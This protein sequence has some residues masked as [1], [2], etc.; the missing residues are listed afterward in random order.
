MASRDP[1]GTGPATSPGQ[2]STAASASTA[3][4]V[5]AAEAGS[6]A[7]AGPD[8]DGAG[9]GAGETEGLATKASAV[10]PGAPATSTGEP[11]TTAEAEPRTE[12]ETGTAPETGTTPESESR[13]ATHTA[14]RTR[15]STSA[16]RARPW[17][18]ARGAAHPP[19][20]PTKPVIAAALV[21]GLLLIGAPFLVAGLS[22]PDDGSPSAS[23][24]EPAGSR[25]GPDGS[26]PGVVPGQQDAP[27]SGRV[28][29]SGA[30]PKAGAP[31]ASGGGPV[32][33]LHEGGTAL[34][35]GGTQPVG[36]KPGPG[37]PKGVDTTP[38]TGTKPSG[39]SGGNGNGAAPGGGASGGTG[40]GTQPVRRPA[41]A[42]YTHFIGPGCDTAGFATSDRFTNGTKGWRGSWNSTK[43][44]GCNG[45]F[46]SLPLSGSSSKASGAYAQWRFPTGKVTKGTCAVQVY[47]PSVRDVSYVG[48]SPAHYTVYRS[49][50][51][52]SDTQVG[53]FEVNQ[54]AHLGQWV[55]AGTF[56]VDQGRLSVILDN[57]GK[58]SGNRHAAAAPVRINCTA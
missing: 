31:R 54:T 5:Q 23:G 53:T 8:P 24:Q 44:Y 32:G 16:T 35:E 25:V 18:A 56:K 38:S 30:K 40:G 45:L 19:G 33:G 41:A 58:T 26:G 12:P 46:Y 17:A 50:K 10:P 39:G 11:A 21:G 55:S 34:H 36:N 20:R 7:A 48:A 52:Q 51:P 47:V 37:S 4:A 13:S 1:Q 2:A 28:P 27:D 49:F 15:T 22:G 14:T 3:V 6:G 29:G 9:P 57:R 42:T 43:S